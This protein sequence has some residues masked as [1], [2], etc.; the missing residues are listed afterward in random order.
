MNDIAD[1]DVQVE[2]MMDYISGLEPDVRIK[3]NPRICEGEYANI[4]V[5]PPLSWDD[6]R[7]LDLQE[8]IGDRVVD[9]LIDT[10]L[11]I[12]VYVYMPEQQIAEARREQELAEK[13]LKAVE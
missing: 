3:L 2:L 1:L 9:A 8:R 10:D 11:L 7:C 6:E 12:S 13:A 4:S 5:Y